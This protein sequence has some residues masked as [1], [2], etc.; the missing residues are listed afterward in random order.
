MIEL[1]GWMHIYATYKCEDLLPQA[2]IDSIMRKVK[3]I[4]SDSDNGIELRYVNGSAFVNTL[5]CSNHRTKE[6]DVIIQAYKS[7]S[8]IA[9]GSYGIL[10]IRDDEDGK[11]FNELQVYV[12]K[13]GQ[14]IQKKDTDFS[15]CI[16]ELEDEIALS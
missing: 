2:E 10:F 11:Y 16:P 6:V 8:E 3:D 13:R 1:H 12:F 9:T 14:C 7:I 4:A 15:P 5:H